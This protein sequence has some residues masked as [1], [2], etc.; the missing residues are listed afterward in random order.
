MISSYAVTTILKSMLAY[1]MA[2]RWLNR[3]DFLFDQRKWE[4]GY[5]PYII[6]LLDDSNFSKGW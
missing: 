6:F 5:S 1:T 4:T 3:G 2:H